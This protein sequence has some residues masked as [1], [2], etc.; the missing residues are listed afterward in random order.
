M[1]LTNLKTG[2]IQKCSP[3][4]LKFLT[5]PKGVFKKVLNQREVIERMRLIQ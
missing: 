4:Q 2:L 5:T 1:K 3:I